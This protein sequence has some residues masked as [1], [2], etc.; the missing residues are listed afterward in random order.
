MPTGRGSKKATGAPS[1]NRVPRSQPKGNP[2]RKSSMEPPDGHVVV[3]HVTGSW[4]LG[5]DVKVHSQSDFPGR[6]S[7][8][9]ELH[10]EGSRETVVSSRP[11]RGGYVIRL[12]GVTN[13]TA[14]DS[15]RGALLTV[16]EDEIA[17]LPEATYYHFQLIDMQVVSDEG[18][19]LGV[20][21]EILDTAANDVYVIR[22]DTSPDLLIP[23]I[24]EFVVD[25]D[26]EAGRMTVHL[27]PGL[28]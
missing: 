11:Y 17:P 4:G 2:S 22:S 8:D 3:G 5:G 26:V 7:L 16:P 6:F 18:E 12:S 23:A 25:V 21:V 24:R 14:A 9:S 20:I 1:K 10:I 27:A 28:R 19:A 15:M 13:R